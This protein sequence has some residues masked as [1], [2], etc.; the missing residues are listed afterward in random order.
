[1]LKEKIYNEVIKWDYLLQKEL[2]SLSQ[3]IPLMPHVFF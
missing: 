2:G 3:E 1:M